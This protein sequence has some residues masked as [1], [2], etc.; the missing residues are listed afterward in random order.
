MK[1]EHKKIAEAAAIAGR[2][3][4][5]S[6]AESYRVEDTVNRI[7]DTSGLAVTEAVATG[8]AL[9]ITLDDPTIEGITRIQRIEHRGN[10]MRKIY[11]VNNISRQLTAQKITVDEALVQLK[12]VDVSEYTIFHHD[13]AIFLLILSFVVLLGGHW[14]ELFVASFAAFI[15][16]GAEYA[17][18]RWGMN[19]FIH[20]I[21]ATSLLGF[22]VPFIIHLCQ[23]SISSDIIIV[24]AL[25]P[26]FPGIAFTNGIRDTL[27]GDYNAGLAKIA[28]AM[29]IAVFLAL[30]IALGLYLVQ[31][32]IK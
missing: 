25:M 8:T 32:V 19:D 5:E 23:Q 29:T 26:L 11:N 4:L 15:I 22:F 31:G 18:N 20:G 17:K 9:F 16:I 10:H 3:L 21:F 30:G 27:K 24:S 13:A 28:E 1:P 6:N 14:M 7:L 2:I 12:K